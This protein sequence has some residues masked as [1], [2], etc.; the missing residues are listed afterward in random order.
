MEDV[1]KDRALPILGQRGGQHTPNT[2]HPLAT[3]P[4]ALPDASRPGARSL[5]IHVPFCFHK[6]HYCDFYSIVDRQDR[7]PAFTDRL[8]HELEAIARAADPLATIFIGGG[9]PTLLRLD[10]LTRVLAAVRTHFDLSPTIEWTVEANPETLTDEV[11]TVLAEGGVN[12][13]S[14]GAQSFD[15]RHLKTLERWHDP[16]SVPRALEAARAAG[17]TRRSLDL[18]FAIPGQT[19]AD[20]AR[21]LDTAFAL[22]TTHLSAYNLTYE[23]ATAMT[24]RLHKGELEPADEDLEIDMLDALVDRTHAAGL[25]RYEV[26]NFAAPGHEC[27]HNLAYWRQHDWLAAGPSASGHVAG[28]RWKNTP[29]L[30]DYLQPTPDHLPPVIDHEPPDPRR[31][32]AER[33]MTGL[34]LREGLP[35]AEMLARAA[36]L[37]A[38]THDRLAAAI[39]NLKTKGHTESD[40]DTI[41]LTRPAMLLADGLA[42]T[43]MA[44][45]EPG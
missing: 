7:Q 27:A 15:P 24:A 40:P 23:P 25:A 9:T 38:D 43:L 26:S 10:L 22:G 1:S 42:A 4:A 2:R 35:R 37:D 36:A 39:D 21:D 44:A 19:L 34:R 20:F 17:I 11:A 32:L 8:V 45:V 28:H 13:V 3:G 41:R 18:I 5:Y 16:E 31:A 30:A 14:V 29:R 33:I 6:C 12:R